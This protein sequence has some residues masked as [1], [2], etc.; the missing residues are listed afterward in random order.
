MNKLTG[1]CLCGA[2]EFRVVDD[3]DYVGNCHCSECRRFTGSDYS[4]A[5][6]VSADKF[7]LVK[8]EDSIR[9]YEKS[10]ATTLAFC[11]VCGSSLFSIK[12]DTGRFNVR[13]GV[14][15]DA[16]SK[17]PGFHISVGSKAPWLEI[18]DDLVRFPAHPDKL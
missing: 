9:Y 5:G 16:P 1:S 6:G 8:G 3:F 4:S 13:L 2:V 15:Q 11:Q 18:H 10:P 17:K 12:S 7:S 14:L